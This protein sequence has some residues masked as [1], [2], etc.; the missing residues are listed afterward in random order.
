MQVG[1]ATCG[2]PTAVEAVAITS[3]S[4][5][6]VPTMLLQPIELLDDLRR[7][8][9]V[10]LLNH[11]EGHGRA[12]QWLRASVRRHKA[13]NRSGSRGIG[14]AFAETSSAVCCEF[15]MSRIISWSVNVER[16]VF[17]SMTRCSGSTLSAGFCC[18]EDA[19]PDADPVVTGP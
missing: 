2:I 12:D 3:S 14:P 1:T 8:V 9:L 16:S 18:P 13:C 4:P 10:F 17:S 7:S 5:Y 11:Q 15:S 6:L 19:S